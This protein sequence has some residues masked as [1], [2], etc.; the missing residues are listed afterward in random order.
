MRRTLLILVPVLLAFPVQAQKMTGKRCPEGSRVVMTG[1]PFHPLECLPA[2]SF[3]V[4]ASS[5]PA[6]PALAKNVKLDDFLGRWEGYA[7][8]G[9]D[10]FEI[11]VSLGKDGLF[12]KSLAA[13]LEA[14][15]HRVP[16]IHVL[17]ARLKAEGAG[18]YAASVL[19]ESSPLPSLKGRAWLGRSSDPA[20]DAELLLVYPNG[21]SH[22][23]RLKRG[24]EALFYSYED[25]AKPGAPSSQ[26]T[27]T[28]TKRGSL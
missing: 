6:A 20:F 15:E 21:A 5:A 8:L 24:K 9:V 14:R 16:L 23:L 3:S 12:G 26:G 10:R 22:R 2:G 25:L 7:V 4:A 19:L 27:L 1:H 17:T 13:R 18:R 28:P 11:L